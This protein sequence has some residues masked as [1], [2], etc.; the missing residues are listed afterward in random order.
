A[1]VGLLI[2]LLTALAIIGFLRPQ[3]N[4]LVDRISHFAG[5]PNRLGIVPRERVR[6]RLAMHLDRVEWIA[7]LETQLD[8]A[9]IDMT[10]TRV[11]GLTAAATVLMIIVLGLLAA[12]FAILGLLT[13]LITRGLIAH[14][15]RQIQ[16]EFAD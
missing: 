10:A 2:A 13:P 7:K 5:R 15:R 14:K 9:R 1:F 6:R 4:T 16:E 11:I 8:I 12:P 3:E